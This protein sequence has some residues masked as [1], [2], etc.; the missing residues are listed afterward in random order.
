MIRVVPWFRFIEEAQ[1]TLPFRNGKCLLTLAVLEGPEPW[2]WVAVRETEPLN[3]IVLLRRGNMMAIKV[4][5]M[6]E[7]FEVERGSPAEKV[8]R[9]A[10]KCVFAEELPDEERWRL[11]IILC[12]RAKQRRRDSD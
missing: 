4:A 8:M 10:V 2:A 7:G 3:Q 11:E 1:V 6:S 5:L 12:R 9:A